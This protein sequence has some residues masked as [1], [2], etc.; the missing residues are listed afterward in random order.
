MQTHSFQTA[1]SIAE[2]VYLRTDPEQLMRLVT[3][4][5]YDAHSKKV[6]YTLSINMANSMHYEFEMSHE[7]DI[8]LVTGT[9]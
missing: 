1:F 8:M 9:N 5:G 3:G 4:I 7:R 6:L 2:E